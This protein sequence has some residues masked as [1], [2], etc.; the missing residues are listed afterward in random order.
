MRSN[1]SNGVCPG[2]PEP[3][4]NDCHQLRD[5][6]H[7]LS[8]CMEIMQITYQVSRRNRYSTIS[9]RA[10]NC[11]YRTE[12]EF[13]RPSC[14]SCRGVIWN[15]E[16]WN[17]DYH[18]SVSNDVQLRA[19]NICEWSNLQWEFWLVWCEDVTRSPFPSMISKDR[20]VV[21][22]ITCCSFWRG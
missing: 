1:R 2:N 17:S 3:P 4:E 9:F 13:R 16:R 6:K 19:S 22:W 20:P 15:M 12:R 10:R 8:D 14:R 18:E 21:R 5:T 11:W 7:T